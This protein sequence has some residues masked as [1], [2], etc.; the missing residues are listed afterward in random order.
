LKPLNLLQNLKT[1]LGFFSE[2][3]VGKTAL[4]FVHVVEAEKSTESLGR[5]TGVRDVNTPFMISR[6]DGLTNCELV[7]RSGSG[8][9]SSLRLS[10]LQG[11]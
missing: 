8:F 3:H 2:K 5:D 4:F 6:T 9:S 1:E 7:I 11:K 10:C